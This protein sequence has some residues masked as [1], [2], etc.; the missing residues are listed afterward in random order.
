MK[1][2][3]GCIGLLLAGWMVFLL[4][5]PMQVSAE[6]VTIIGVVSSD[7]QLETEEG[8]IYDF[9]ASEIADELLDYVGEKVKVTGTIIEDDGNEVLSVESFIIVDEE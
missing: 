3:I 5:F 2:K 7:Y 9:A 6:T 4:M 8:D 1:R